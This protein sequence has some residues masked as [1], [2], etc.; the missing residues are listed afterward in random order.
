MLHMRYPDAKHQNM[1]GVTHPVPSVQEL[2]HKVKQA[3]VDSPLEYSTDISRAMRDALSPDGPSPAITFGENVYWKVMLVNAR[4]KHVD[5]VDPFGTGFLHSVRTSI[6]DF[7]QR[8]N[9]GT[10][11]FTGWT[12]RLQPRG[13][14]WNC[15]MWA[16]W[17]QEKWMQ[18][19]SRTEATEAFAD[20]LRQD[21]NRI[22]QGQNLRKHYHV[23]MQ[24]AGTAA[25]GGTTELYQSREISASRM[26]NQRDKQA[27]YDTYKERMHQHASSE[28]ASRWHTNAQRPMKIPDSPD[29]QATG[30]G[31]TQ[32]K[33]VSTIRLHRNLGNSTCACTSA[34]L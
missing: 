2:L 20:W 12:K 27:L 17:I 16:I 30:S 4:R 9:T 8:N 11:T 6:Q 28:S 34:T 33:K 23:V 14:T 5:F 26:A 18:Y 1:A 13:D 21:I 15:G 3:D 22:P 29:I 31:H 32:S 25:E 7:Y 10:W 19:W 24:L